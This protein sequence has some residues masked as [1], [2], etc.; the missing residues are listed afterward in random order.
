MSW[1]DIRIVLNQCKKSGEVNWISPEL[2][3]LLSHI[4]NWPVYLPA[5]SI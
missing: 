4:K 2:N 5:P 1:P 3:N